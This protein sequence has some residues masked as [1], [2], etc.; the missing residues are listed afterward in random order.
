MSTIRDVAKM[1]QVSTAT[2]SRVLNH[3]PRYKITE[4]TKNRVLAAVK[5]LD[6][7]LQPRATHSR[8]STPL[9]PS[10][11]KIGCILSITKGKYNDP[12]F[13]SVLSGVESQL[14]SKGYAL[15][16]ICTEN[17]LGDHTSLVS[18][19][20]S[21]VSGLII[22]ETLED[23]VYE[24]I[25]SKVPCIVGIDTLRA[26][27]DNVA[28]DHH[29]VGT[30]AT[31]HLINL[32]H[33][34]IGFIGG[35]GE[36]GQIPLSRRYQGYS[37]AMQ[38]AGLPVNP[39]WVIDC[40]WDEDICAQ[41]LRELC[42]SDNLPTAFFAASDLM[43]ISAISTFEENRIAVP[44][45]VAVIGMSDIEIARFTVPP[46]TTLRVPKEELGMVAANLLIERLGGSTLPPQKV[47][48]PSK[49]IKRGTT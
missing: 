48:L 31:Q 5:A 43:A 3:D 24:Y 42:K 14:Q 30:Q 36:S 4:E 37:I 21:N 9:D 32:G 12:Y 20:D 39:D 49:L 45:R 2:V 27:I 15:S 28:Y 47:T 13:M 1:A 22:M 40:R 10:H 23:E 38:A 17:K 26:D 46:L 29:Q 18:T 44:D 41:K 33:T 6:Y 25:R 7:K 19:F 34:K 16:F 35:S 8:T 11:A